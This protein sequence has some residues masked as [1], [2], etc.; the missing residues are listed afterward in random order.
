[1]DDCLRVSFKR[2]YIYTFSL[3]HT[4]FGLQ[5]EMFP[6]KGPVP[7]HACMHATL[8]SLKSS[9]NLNEMLTIR[10]HVGSSMQAIVEKP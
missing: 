2:V 6:S 3:S 4:V 8:I 9:Q 1:M 5:P 10:T 7:Q